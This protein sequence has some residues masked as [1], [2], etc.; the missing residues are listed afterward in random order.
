MSEHSYTVTIVSKDVTQCAIKMVGTA[1]FAMEQSLHVG[2]Y[3]SNEFP[4]TKHKQM[5]PQTR[6]TNIMLYYK[7]QGV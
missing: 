5:L 7:E 2:M 1:F 3:N 6:L 4:H